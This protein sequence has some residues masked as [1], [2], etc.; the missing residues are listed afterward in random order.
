M[1]TCTV[2]YAFGDWVENG[3][4]AVKIDFSRCQS[5]N[6]AGSIHRKSRRDNTGKLTYAEEVI[7][8]S[9]DL[10]HGRL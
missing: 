5:K 1:G 3:D 7:R 6:V 2:V 9:G 10:V 8:W 4:V